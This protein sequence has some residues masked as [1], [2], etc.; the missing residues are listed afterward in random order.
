M[1]SGS[2][3]PF[4][5]IWADGSPRL[6]VAR[7]RPRRAVAATGRLPALL[8][9]SPPRIRSISAARG[10]WATRWR[11]GNARGGR[12]SVGSTGRRR[13]FHFGFWILDFGLVRQ[14]QD[15]PLPRL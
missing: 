12:V 10:T 2:S 9:N 14:R 4:T 5:N 11:T 15:Q 8:R 6:A 13:F 7:I 3:P 1:W